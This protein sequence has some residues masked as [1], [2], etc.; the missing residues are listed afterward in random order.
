[1]LNEFALGDHVMM[2]KPHPCGSNEWEIVRDGADIKI[3]CLKC[4]RIVMLDRCDFI[5][6][7]KKIIMVVGNDLGISTDK[8]VET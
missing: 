3:K 5:R 2:R 6:S 8:N 1:M 4:G 7:A